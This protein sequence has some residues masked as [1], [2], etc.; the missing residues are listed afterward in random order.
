VLNSSWCRA[1]VEATSSALAGGFFPYQKRQLADLAVPA[2]T[3]DQRARLRAATDR[4]AV[5]AVLA[6]AY[7][8][9]G[10]AAALV[11]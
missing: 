4:A 10:R 1:W 11:A 2:L 5:D 8:L 6:E 3:D 7:G 9:T